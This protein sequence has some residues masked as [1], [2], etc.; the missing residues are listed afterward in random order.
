MS[1]NFSKSC[2]ALIYMNKT[3][4]AN[5]EDDLDW[6]LDL[7][8]PVDDR[9]KMGQVYQDVIGYNP[10]D[11]FDEKELRKQYKELLNYAPANIKDTLIAKEDNI[12]SK[13]IIRKNATIDDRLSYLLALEV[14]EEVGWSSD[15]LDDGPTQSTFDNLE[16]D[17]EETLDDPESDDDFRD[18]DD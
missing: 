14:F 5:S 11:Y 9:A 10:L 2:K 18:D 17:E 1:E 13:T 6:L 8:K 7:M 16:E 4:H 12:I 15:D 3:V